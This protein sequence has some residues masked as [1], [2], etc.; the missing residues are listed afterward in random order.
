MQ[1]RTA[2]AAFGLLVLGPAHALPVEE[3]PVYELRCRGGGDGFEFANLGLEPRASGEEAFVLLSLAFTP[4]PAGAGPNAQGLR[5]G[6]CAWIDRAVNHAEPAAIQFTTPAYGQLKQKTLDTSLTAAE[7]YPDV[8]SIAHYLADPNHYW[9]FFAYNTNRGYLLA[10]RH[11]FWKADAIAAKAWKVEAAVSGGI[12]GA[13]TSVTVT[14]D[15]QVVMDS[16]RLGIHCS[17]QMSPADL[18]A[19]DEV[20]SKA[21]PASWLPKYALPK[22]PNG[23]CDMFQMLLRLER[24]D[25]QGSRTQ[26]S[27]YWYTDSDDRVPADIQQLFASAFGAR[28]VCLTAPGAGK[29]P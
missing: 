21:R 19:L 13:T 28:K 26:H 24:Q 12:E 27:T 14:A 10:A 22:N 18:H 17:Q 8:Q 29:Q 16:P 15:G 1:T 6:T 7:R 20:V 2:A 23:C 11:R 25:A 5:P 4:G 9:S 3:P